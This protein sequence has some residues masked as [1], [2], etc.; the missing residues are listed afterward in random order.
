[1]KKFNKPHPCSLCGKTGHRKG[2]CPERKKMQSKRQ[3]SLDHATVYGAKTA[4]A[5]PTLKGLT[6]VGY[7]EIC[8]STEDE[9]R[10]KL[11]D[12]GVLLPTAKEQSR[13]C[14]KCGSAMALAENL[15]P[16]AMR[17]TKRQRD[18][19]LRRADVAHTL[20]WR[21]Q[22]AGQCS[23]K[24]ILNALY[25]YGCK[26]PQDAA[27]HLLGCSYGAAENWCKQVRVATAVAELHTGRDMTFPDGTLEFDGTKTVISR[28]NQKTNKHC[29]RFLVVYHRE[30]GTYA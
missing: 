14:W 18:T 27:K 10:Q 12:L 30:S 24:V 21:A 28:A 15:G 19:Q 1:M 23:H 13:G 29:G 4:H 8:A 22:K 3:R 6:Q 26:V 7:P 11:E 9:A 25:V 16:Q 20:A 17:C 2:T 5:Q